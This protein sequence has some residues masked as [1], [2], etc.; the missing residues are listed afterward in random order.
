MLIIFM[1]IIIA[2][3]VGLLT[4]F[5]LRILN[6]WEPYATIKQVID[7][8]KEYIKGEKYE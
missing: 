2:F 8:I 5:L 7:G 3:I 4:L 6:L 1:F